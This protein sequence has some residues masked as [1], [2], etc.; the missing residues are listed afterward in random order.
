MEWLFNILKKIKNRAKQEYEQYKESDGFAQ[1]VAGNAVSLA[2]KSAKFLGEEKLAEKIE[3]SRES[4]LKTAKSVDDRVREEVQRVEDKFKNEENKPEEPKEDETVN[5]ENKPVKTANS[6]K[7]TYI[8]S[9]DHLCPE[10]Q[11]IQFDEKKLNLM[12]TKSFQNA[13]IKVVHDEKDGNTLIGAMVDGKPHGALLSLDTNGNIQDI[14]VYNLGEE[15]SLEGN[16][17]EINYA[18]SPLGAEHYVTMLN[19]NKFGWELLKDQNGCARVAF[20]DSGFMARVQ[21]LELFEQTVSG[22]RYALRDEL[23]GQ[24]AED[25]HLT[26]QLALAQ[27]TCDLSLHN[28]D[29]RDKSAEVVVSEEKSE[30]KLVAQAT[31]VKGIDSREM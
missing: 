15:V 5:K 27:A 19:G 25:Q 23:R 28:A 17:I 26:G 13:K 4:V 8:A 30:S 7:D 3:S 20:Y 11:A 29:K 18:K 24:S 14:K 1:Y 2:N 31:P 22:D 9:L 21:N 10:M 6:K 12:Q 16:Q